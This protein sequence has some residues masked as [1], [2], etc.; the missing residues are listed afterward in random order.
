MNKQHITKHEQALA[1]LRSQVDRARHCGTMRLP[2]MKVLA[3]GAGVSYVPMAHAV[4][5]LKQEGVLESRPKSGILVRTEPVDTPCSPAASGQAS[6]IPRWR[7]VVE[8]LRA[9]MLSNTYRENTFLPSIKELHEQLNVSKGTV[10]KALICLEK[11]DCVKR[12]GRRYRVCSRPRP[13]SRSMIAIISPGNR[14]GH[15]SINSPRMY[16]TIGSIERACERR[17]IQSSLVA[18]HCTTQTFTTPTGEVIHPGFARHASE[19][20]LGFVVLKLAFGDPHARECLSYL[21]RRKLPIALLDEGDT[22]PDR[23]IALVRGSKSVRV[24]SAGSGE[25]AGETV[26]E[27]LFQSN[28]RSVAYVTLDGVS[29]ACNARFK[30]LRAAM[31][32][33][34]RGADVKHFVG[35]GPGRGMS[36]GHYH[37]RPVLASELPPLD[38]ADDVTDDGRIYAFREIRGMSGNMSFYRKRLGDLPE[39]ILANKSISAWVAFTD[40]IAVACMEAV[41]NAGKKI[42]DDISLVGFD[43]AQ[44]AQVAQ[45]TSYDFNSPGA[46]EPIVDY[47]VSPTRFVRQFGNRPITALPGAVI[48]RATTAVRKS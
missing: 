40:E 24:F 33:N 45:L 23:L 43:N 36:H 17:N 15:I 12:T 39:R 46:A 27:F 22:P 16:D 19:T 41:V 3:Q 26:G 35:E 14:A 34:G 32:R 7:A 4:R 44:V 38:A 10:R 9:D 5:A 28:H 42:P 37:A 2:T 25:R 31:V 6:G 47:I 11:V 13:P 30:G 8:A 21:V 48:R 20:L 29:Y 18:Y 1:Y